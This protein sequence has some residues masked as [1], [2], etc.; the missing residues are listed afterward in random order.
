[1][2]ES[3]LLLKKRPWQGYVPVNFAKFLRTH[4][5]TEHLRWLLLSGLAILN[6][7]FC[8][9][10]DNGVAMHFRNKKLKK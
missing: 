1:M 9:V 6:E 2:P 4:F 8:P 7:V 10:E 5:L 3:L